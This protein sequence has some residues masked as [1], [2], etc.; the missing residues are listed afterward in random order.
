MFRMNNDSVKKAFKPAVL[1]AGAVCVIVAAATLPVDRL[2]VSFAVLFAFTIGI[3]SQ[4]TVPIPRFK[5]RISVSDTFIFLALLLY[6]GQF[7]ILL[8]VAEAWFSS[9]KFCKK[10]ITVILNMASMAISTALAAIALMIFGLYNESALHGES[11]AITEFT[12]ALCIIAFTQFFANTLI[13]ATHESLENSIPIWETWKDNYLWTFITYLIGAASAGVLVKMSGSLGFGVIFATFPVI[14]FIFF[15][16]KTYMKNVEMSVK[17]A[18][19]A[20]EHANILQERSAALRESEHRFRSAFTYAPIGIA[21]VSPKGRWL[22]VNNALS[23]ILGYSNKEFLS[24]YFQSMIFPED[25]PATLNMIDALS[26]GRLENCQME[27]R[28]IHKS[29]QTVWALWSVSAASDVHSEHSNLIFQIQDITDKKRAEAKLQHEATHDALTG[30]PNRSQF[31]SRLESAINKRSLDENYNVSILFI[32][33]DRFKNVND[34]LGHLVGDQLL[35]QIAD[36]LRDCVRPCDMI[37]R[38]GGDEFTIMVEGKYDQDE[39]TSIAQRI[40]KKFTAPFDVD[41]NIV[42]SSASVGVLHSCDLHLTGQDMMRDA[43]TAMYHAKRAGKA[44]HEVFDANMH[45]AVKETLQLETDLRRAIADKNFSVYYQPI[46]S[47][48]DGRIEGIEALARWRHPVIGDIPPRK[49]IETAEEI[50]LIDELA[51]QIMRQAFI[52][53]G[54][55]IE[56]IPDLR[57]IRLSINLSSRQIVNRDLMNTVGQVLLETGF[58]AS[59]LKLEITE[60]AFLENRERAIEMLHNVRK[61]GIEIDIDDFGTGYSNL[62][63][64]TRLPISSLKIDGSFIDTIAETGTHTEIVRAILALAQSLNVKVIA[65]GVETEQQLETLKALGCNAAQGFALAQPMN[66][67]QVERFVLE[68]CAAKLP[69]FEGLSVVSTVQ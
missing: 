63:C 59:N 17:Q 41:G 24:G 57:Q 68:K 27:H 55:I 46:F 9:R 30:L 6:G 64:L 48:P 62:A 49:F 16:Y 15:T 5:S 20:K 8:A 2:D 1:A 36:R 12:L 19:Q 29:G 38:L 28:Y 39:V 58:S 13:A 54:G 42:Y 66:L 4:I 45:R 22:K 32:D 47:L 51:T 33:L 53:I 11:G 31:M 44:R 23:K 61:M 14:L 26:T 60:S 65:E 7:A 56:R 34:S 3:G 10:K 40:N 69:S 21:L 18:R 50:G 37:A 52:D 25:L 35:I 43:D 67:E